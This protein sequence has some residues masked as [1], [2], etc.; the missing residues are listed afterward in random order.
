MIEMQIRMPKRLATS[1]PK[2]KAMGGVTKMMHIKAK[3][4]NELL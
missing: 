2:T 3:H 4:Q 1:K